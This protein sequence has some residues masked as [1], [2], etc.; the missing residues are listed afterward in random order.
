LSLQHT[1]ESAGLGGQPYRDGSYEYYLR[2]PQR[3][4]DFKGIGAF[5]MAANE[6][7]RTEGDLLRRPKVVMLDYFYN[8]EWKQTGAT[9]TQ[10]HYIWE[11]TANSGFSRLG[12]V[13]EGL[14]AALGELHCAPVRTLLDQSSVY[15]IVD[16]D[17]PAESEHP[18]Y[19]SDAAVGEIAAWVSEGGVLVLMGNDKGNAEFENL[20][21]LAGQFG[22]R[23]NEDSYHRVVGNNFD[24]G[25]FSDL[26]KHPIFDGVTQI[27]LKEICSLTIDKPAEAVLTEDG[28][29]FMASARVGKGTV[30]AVGDPW[31]YNEYIDARKLPSGFQNMKAAENMFQ[32][33]LGKAQLSSN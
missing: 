8:C 29:V 15:M 4:N 20:N 19:I 26:P 23:F 32:W 12:Q 13:I 21:K 16:P 6:I 24:M 28:H 10:Y 27:Y 18:R 3:A 14:G 31:L 7:E 22:I 9:K 5:L 17:T 33:L 1:C 2:E 25:K 11:D 30:F